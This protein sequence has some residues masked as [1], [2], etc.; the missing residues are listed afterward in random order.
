MGVTI[1]G[2]DFI[3]VDIDAKSIRS[4]INIVNKNQELKEKIE[5]RVQAK[6]TRFFKGILDQ[7]EAVTF[8]MCNPPFHASK[9]Q[10]L[11]GS[12]R[13]TFHLTGKKTHNPTLNFAGVH[14]ELIYEGGEFAFISGMIEE[15]KLFAKQVQWFTTLVS[16][17]EYIKPMQKKLENVGCKTHKVIEMKT[18]NK[19]TRILAWRF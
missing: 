13:K 16:K 18:G 6:S 10:A 11:E 1:Y 5:C 19:Q 15:S 17:N 8:T 12:K 3:A 2:W 9:E 14:N 7:D 4:S